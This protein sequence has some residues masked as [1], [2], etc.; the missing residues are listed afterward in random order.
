MPRYFHTPQFCP[1]NLILLKGID[2]IPELMLHENMEQLLKPLLSDAQIR[3][4]SNVLR[5]M[6]S[7]DVTLNFESTIEVGQEL[8]LQVDLSRQRVYISIYI[9]LGDYL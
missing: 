8:S 4:I 9:T 3:D 5:K 1:F 2:C 7:I 6:P